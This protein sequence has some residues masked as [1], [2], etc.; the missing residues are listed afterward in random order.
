ML[1]IYLL[2]N[3]LGSI[4]TACPVWACELMHGLLTYGSGSL[5]GALLLLLQEILVVGFRYDVKKTAHTIMSQPAKLGAHDFVMARLVRGEVDRNDH[6]WNGVLLKAQLA[7]VKIVNHVLG[8]D[9][10]LDLMI[11]RNG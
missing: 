3:P 7:N 4:T 2:M 8:T 9:E 11:H 6:P 10:Q 1:K 5:G